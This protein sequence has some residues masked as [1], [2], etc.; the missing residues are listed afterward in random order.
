MTEKQPHIASKTFQRP[1]RQMQEHHCRTIEDKITIFDIGLSNYM[2]KQHIWV[3]MTRATK[4]ENVTIFLH[5]AS[6]KNVTANHLS[7]STLRMFLL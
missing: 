7:K 4:L 1:K 3:A 6:E 2:S 5:S